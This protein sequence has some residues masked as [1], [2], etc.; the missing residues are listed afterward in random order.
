M[1]LLKTAYMYFIDAE[2]SNDIYTYQEAKDGFHRHREA[3]E[4]RFGKSVL[5]SSTIYDS[6]ETETEEN[7][8]R[9][10]C[11]RNHLFLNTLNDLIDDNPSFMTDSLHISLITTDVNQIRPPFNQ[12]KEEYIY[13]R[14]LLYEV[15]NSD[16]KVHYA[17]KETHLDDVLNYS[18]IFR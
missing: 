8:Y 2:Q 1:V 9:Y 12:V 15:A 14:Y 3:M 18:C 13:A 10:W 5:D 7:A 16:G 17:D 6:V 11:L 4:K